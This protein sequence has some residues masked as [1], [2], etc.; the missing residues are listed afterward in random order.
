MKNKAGTSSEFNVLSITKQSVKP[1]YMDALRG[2]VGRGKA[3][4]TEDAADEL[5]MELSTMHSH[6]G[7][8]TLP[9]LPIFL[10]HA[11]YFGPVF[12]DAI[13]EVAGMNGVR[14]IGDNEPDP[15]ELNADIAK[16]CGMLGACLR[17]RQVDARERAVMMPV[18]RETYAVLGQWLATH[19]GIA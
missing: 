17:D 13:L 6:L 8:E 1:V 9:S 4:S 11:R 7:G 16:L 18:A 15:F 14:V 19:G 3:L 5:G 2:Y 12:A 10:R